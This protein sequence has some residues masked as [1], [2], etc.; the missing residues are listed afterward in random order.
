V[1]DTFDPIYDFRLRNKRFAYPALKD[2]VN[3]IRLL[4]AEY[5]KLREENLRLKT[6]LVG[7]ATRK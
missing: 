1:S 4:I 2:A 6:E 7:K 5:D 3:D